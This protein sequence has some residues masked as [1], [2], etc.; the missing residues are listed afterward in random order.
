MPKVAFVTNFIPIYRF[1]VFEP[2]T[3]ISGLDFVIFS[4]M[5]LSDSCREAIAN[6]PIK[7][8]MGLNFPRITKHRGVGASQK[9]FASLPLNLALDLMGFRPNLIVSGDLGVRSFVCWCVARII[10]ARLVLWSEEIMTSG[11]GR[12]RPQQWLRRFLIRRAD[13][14]LAWGT[15]ATA[16]LKSFNAPNAR[17]FTCAQAVDNDFWIEQARTIDREETRTRLGFQGVVFLL[18]GRAVQLKGFQNFLAAWA[19][20][21]AAIH[22]KASAI[23]VGDGDYL[24]DL[25]GIAEDLNLKNVVFAGAR[26]PP[27]LARFYA[28]ADIFVFPSL[29]DVWGLVVNEAMCFGLPIL[30]SKYAGASQ[31]LIAGSAA[32]I[33]FDPNDAEEFAECLRAWSESPPRRAPKECQ[34]ILAD[35]SF[36]RSSEVIQQLIE[37][38]AC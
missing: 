12:S 37:A 29:V 32:G 26:T 3:G 10:G 38:V 21:S 34:E 22:S 5:P 6:L 25:K 28:A 35:I 17:I 30:A 14:F 36:K 4:S 13:A 9:E 24:V 31:G 2:L 18:V 19:G 1:P 33:V 16:Y 20:Q 7:H 11:V 23:I 8:T 27:E 15:P